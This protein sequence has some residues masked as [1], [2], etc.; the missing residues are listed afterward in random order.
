MRSIN[1][2]PVCLFDSKEIGEFRVDESMLVPV[3]KQKTCR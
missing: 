3:G 1:I 2:A